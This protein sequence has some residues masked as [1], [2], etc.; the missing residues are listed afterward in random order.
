MDGGNLFPQTDVDDLHA[1]RISF[2]EFTFRSST[3]PYTRQAQVLTES[4]V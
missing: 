1:R 2:A 4:L 3:S